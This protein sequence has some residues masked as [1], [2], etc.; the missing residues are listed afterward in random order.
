MTPCNERCCN[1]QVLVWVGG[2]GYVP[3]SCQCVRR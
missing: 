3:V 1:R 2:Q